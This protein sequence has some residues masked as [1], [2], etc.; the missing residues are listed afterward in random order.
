MATT[1][2]AN[3]GCEVMDLLMAVNEVRET[4]REIRDRLAGTTK[5]HYTVEEVAEMTGRAPYTVRTWIKAGRLQAERVDGSGPRGRLLIPHGEFAQLIRTG[6][7]MKI[8][9]AVAEANK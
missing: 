2:Q 6:R 9:S 1:T 7:G 4:V 5:S 8:A 3:A